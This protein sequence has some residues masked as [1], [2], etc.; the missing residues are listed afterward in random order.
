MVDD[1]SDFQRLEYALKL[2]GLSEQ[3]IHFIWTTIAAILHLGNVEFEESLDDSR[4][5]CKVFNGSEQDLI[6]AARLLGLETMEL[7]MGLCARI[8]QVSDLENGTRK[9]SRSEKLQKFFK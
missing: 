7:K 5:G 8:M 2:T 9:I 4:G 6:Q 1:F 3:E